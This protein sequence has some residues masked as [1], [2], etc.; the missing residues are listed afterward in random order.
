MTDALIETFEDAAQLEAGPEQDSELQRAEAYHRE[1]LCSRLDLKG[2][3]EVPV[4]PFEPMSESEKRVYQTLCPADEDIKTF[5]RSTIPTRILDL[6]DK[7]G[8]LFI[9]IRIW[10]DGKADPLVVGF[11]SDCWNAQPYMLARWGSELLAFPTLR[12]MAVARRTLL[13]KSKAEE[14][15]IT[16][17]T[18]TRTHMLGGSSLMYS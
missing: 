2:Q 1:C 4:V 8:H 12:E 10:H 18:R 17:E 15:L 6:L 16:A 14:L 11:T 3:T 13:E 5:S 9:K 7:W